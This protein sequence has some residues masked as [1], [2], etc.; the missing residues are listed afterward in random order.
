M[1][2]AFEGLGRI[3]DRLGPGYRDLLQGAAGMGLLFA[4]PRMARA[5]PA[6]GN[7]NYMGPKEPFF[8]WVSKRKDVD[9]KGFYDVIAHG[10]TSKIE[11]QT[12]NGV[13]KVNHRVAAR[14]I[15]QAPGY[16]KGQP[17]RLLSCDTGKGAG[18]FAQNL[19]NKMGVKVE[20]PT[21]LL[22]ARP[23]GDKFVAGGQWA[24]TA[25]GQTRLVPDMSKPGNF[26]LFEPFKKP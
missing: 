5:K 2:A 9:P 23:N 10:S 11:V 4:G 3:G 18:S 24:R 13:M 8:R 25:N 7:V 1:G 6:P 21:E 16:Q 20:A 22:W 12:A 15:E 26:R 14:L 17:I 19:A